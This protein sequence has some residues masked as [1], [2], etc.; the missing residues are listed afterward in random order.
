MLWVGSTI[1]LYRFDPRRLVAGEPPLKLDYSAPK[2][3]V[4]DYMRNESRFRSIERSD[5]ARYK[6]FVRQSQAAAERRYAVYEQLAGI[7]APAVQDAEEEPVKT[8][9]MET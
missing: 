9:L 7:T 8:D 1:G 5:P 3:R 4:G 2:G 6:E